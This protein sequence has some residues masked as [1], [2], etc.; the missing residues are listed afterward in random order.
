VREDQIGIRLTLGEK[1][2]VDELVR[3]RHEETGDDSIAG[4]F[5]VLLRREAKAAGVEIL[6]P[7]EKRPASKGAKRRR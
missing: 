3:R 1:A 4:W 7:G 2:A 6:E 5:R